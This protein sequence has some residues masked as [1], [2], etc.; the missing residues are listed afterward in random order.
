MQLSQYPEAIATAAKSVVMLDQTIAEY[1]D[2]VNAIE[3]EVDLTVQFDGDLKNAEQRKARKSEVLAVHDEHQIKVRLIAKAQHDRA[4]AAIVLEQRRNEFAV[5]KLE[6]R[7]KIA[8][9]VVEF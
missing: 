2:A 7:L 1:R 8:D 5:L 9:S 6:T 3:L 4:I